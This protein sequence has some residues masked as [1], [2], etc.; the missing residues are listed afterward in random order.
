MGKLSRKD[1]ARRIAPLLG[2]TVKNCL[3][4]VDT[5]TDEILR[6]LCRNDE[7]ELWTLGKM[8]LRVRDKH[9][10]VDPR[11]QKPVE[12]PSKA[13]PWMEFQASAKA[14]IQAAH[15]ERLNQTQPEGQTNVEKE[16]TN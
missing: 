8:S 4:V 9:M 5:F 6:A 12:V 1:L 14:R 15:T 2:L 11:T 16:T 3:T 13:R 10:G 7:V